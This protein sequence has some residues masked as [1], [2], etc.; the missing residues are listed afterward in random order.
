MTFQAKLRETVFS[1]GKMLSKVW[2][3]Y[4]E[5]LNSNKQTTTNA[6]RRLKA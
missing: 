6:F 2:L 3:L 4:L 5:E 1:G